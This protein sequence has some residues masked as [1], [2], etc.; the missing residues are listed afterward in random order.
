MK[1]T[2]KVKMWVDKFPIRDPD[3]TITGFKQGKILPGQEFDWYGDPN[4]LPPSYVATPVEKPEPAKAAAPKRGRPPGAKNK[5]K[6][7]KPEVVEAPSS[8]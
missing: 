4:D 7:E 3:G 2:A 1:L 8:E 6:V 5:P